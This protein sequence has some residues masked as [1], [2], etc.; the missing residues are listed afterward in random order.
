MP[1]MHGEYAPEICNCNYS[2]LSDALPT[3]QMAPTKHR[4]Y[5]EVGTN[6]IISQAQSSKAR[7]FFEQVKV[8]RKMRNLIF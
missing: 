3:K 7:G 4:G 2:I 6:N 8:Q 1:C 5:T